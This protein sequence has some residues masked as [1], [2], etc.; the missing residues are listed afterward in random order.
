MNSYDAVIGIGSQ[1]GDISIK[2]LISLIEKTTN[3]QKNLILAGVNIT[4][5]DIELDD[6]EKYETPINIIVECMNEIADVNSFIYATDDDDGDEFILFTEKMPWDYMQREKNF[7]RDNIVH[8]LETLLK[9]VI[10]DF[11]IEDLCIA[12]W[13]SD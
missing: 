13:I 12:N 8:Y 11:E 1:V 2:E 10:K 7:T 5:P 3:V 4:D 6:F 9:P